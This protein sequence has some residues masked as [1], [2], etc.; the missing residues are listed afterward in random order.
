MKV[1]A[2][3]KKNRV[4]VYTFPTPPQIGKPDFRREE[5]RERNRVS[6]HAAQHDR[7]REIVISRKICK[8]SVQI[9]F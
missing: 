3:F 1:F 8:Q 2:R 4:L 9:K 5:R 6:S 7:G